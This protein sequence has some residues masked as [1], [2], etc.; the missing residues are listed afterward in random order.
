MVLINPHLVGIVAMDSKTNSGKSFKGSVGVESYQERLPRQL[1]EGRQK[2]LMLGLADTVTNCKLA[3]AKAKL[4]ESDIIMERFDYT[5]AK[6]GQPQLPR[7]ST[8]DHGSS[9]V[10]AIKPKPADLAKL[11]EQYTKAQAKRVSE[12]TLKL[13]YARVAGHISKLPTRSLDDAIGIR[14]HLL[15]HNSAYTAHR[16]WVQLN[17]C[18]FTSPKTSAI[19]A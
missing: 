17:A 7:W 15:A 3:Q 10:T 11:W 6:Y 18:K 5:L 12:T 16:I 14:D 19:S 4:I 13:N 8:T 1:F 2:Y 9:A